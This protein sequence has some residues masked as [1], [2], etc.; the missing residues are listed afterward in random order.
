MEALIIIDLQAAFVG[1]RL[2]EKEFEETI[3]TINGVS[4][5]FRQAKRPVIV[6]RDVSAGDNVMYRNVKELSIHESDHEILKRQHNSF[7]GTE[8]DTLLRT[9]DVD[10]VVLAGS[11]AEYCV[12]ATYFGALER[13]YTTALLQN[14]VLSECEA[15]KVSMMKTKPLVSYE[16]LHYYLTK[17]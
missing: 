3:G 12:M 4:D 11:A 8:L 16:T 10:Y 5:M 1:H 13:G 7:S 14:G 17:P 2:N 9:L 6:V 15:G